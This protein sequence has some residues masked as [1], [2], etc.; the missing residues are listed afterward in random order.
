MPLLYPPLAAVP[1]NCPMA[2]DIE[3]IIIL[4]DTIP[5]GDS[6]PGSDRTPFLVG[7]GDV[8]KWIADA[9]LTKPEFLLL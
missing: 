8:M 6:K 9:L 5:T 3:A 7:F 4:G 2:G 1:E